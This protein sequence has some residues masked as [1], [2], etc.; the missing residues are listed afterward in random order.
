MF[1]ISFLMTWDQ[2]ELKFDWKPILT[3][4]F[5]ISF[6]IG[7]TKLEVYDNIRNLLNVRRKVTVNAT[8]QTD[9]PAQH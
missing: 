6:K 9:N 8:V 1:D 5:L 3:E 2:Q 4:W 7:K